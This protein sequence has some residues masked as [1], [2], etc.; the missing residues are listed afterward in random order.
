MKNTFKLLCIKSLVLVGLFIVQPIEA[1]K[2]FDVIS[3]NVLEGLQRD[4]TNIETFVKWAKEKDADVIAYQEM[5]KFSQKE[6]EQLAKRYGHPYAIMSKKEG[7]PVAISSKYPIVNVR[8]V[9]DN[10]WHAFIY[11]MI[12]DIHF[13]VIHFSPF[14]YEKRLEEINNV[15]AHAKTLP[16]NSKIL[17]MGDFNSVDQSDAIQ[18]TETMLEG[19]R[20]R[21]EKQAHVRNL[22]NQQMDYSVMKT[23]KDAGFIDTYWLTNKES[24][25]SI[26]T[27]KYG[28]ANR[29][30]DFLWASP[31]IASQVVSSTIIHD[32]Y[33]DVMS[34]HYPVYVKFN[35]NK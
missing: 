30:I 14:S 34:D 15:L 13:Y 11:A 16:E 25:Y 26:T 2:T 33:T 20:K 32:E 5:N 31:S 6:L 29:R 23:I 3:Y 9:V 19:M 21:E 28:K 1:Q 7:F 10:M 8:K 12:N 17:I 35:L 22:N 24:T 27:K 4:S 18:H